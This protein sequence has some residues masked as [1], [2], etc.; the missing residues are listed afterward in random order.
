MNKKRVSVRLNIHN[1][2]M[3]KNI[4]DTLFYDEEKNRG[5]FSEA[6][7]WVLGTFRNRTTYKGMIKFLQHYADYSRGNRDTETVERVRQFLIY[8]KRIEEAL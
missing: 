6:L 3:V 8:Q 7:N 1:Y 4:A 5:N 2:D